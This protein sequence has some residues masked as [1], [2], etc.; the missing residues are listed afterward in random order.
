[1]FYLRY[2]NKVE[3]FITCERCKGRGKWTENPGTQHM[4]FPDGTEYSFLT[5][6][7]HICWRCHGTGQTV[8][9]PWT[10][11]RSLPPLVTR[12]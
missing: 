9:Y 11:G 6:T 4:R 1:M 3:K 10:R 2:S 7:A 5:G 8:T 12:R